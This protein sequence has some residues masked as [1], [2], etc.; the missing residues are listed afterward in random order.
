MYLKKK[1]SFLLLFL[2]CAAWISFPVLASELDGNIERI[3]TTLISGWA[4]DKQDAE[5]TVMV[6]LL[7]YADGSSTVAKTL[8]VKAD[9]HN[10]QSTLKMGGGK[11]FFSSPINWNNLEGT[12][13]RIEGYAICGDERFLLPGEST[14]SKEGAVEVGPGVAKSVPEPELFPVEPFIKKGASL[15]VF[16]TTAYCSCSKCSSG[17]NL[18][19]SGTVPQANHTISADIS[20]FPMGTK[21]MIGDTVYTVEDIG[22]SVNGRKLDIFFDSHAEALEYGRKS[23]EVFAVE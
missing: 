14:Y 23:V 9:K 4:L 12:T 16:T 2:L 3:G 11:H 22:S 6:E 7:I 17:Q 21:L 1:V 5:E 19:Y 20:V 15:G 8:K 18:T 10:E 13:F